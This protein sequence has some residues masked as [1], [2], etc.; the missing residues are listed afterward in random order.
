MNPREK[1]LLIVVISL[2]VLIGGWKGYG[3]YDEW[4]SDLDRQIERKEVIRDK[5]SM[6]RR[7]AEIGAATWRKIGKQT[8]SLEPTEGINIQRDE[9]YALAERVGLKNRSVSPPRPANWRKNGVRRLSCSLSA[10]G[11]V[12]QIVAFLYELETQP[13]LV[14][15]TS[16]TLEPSRKREE[17]GLMAL[18]LRL[19]TLVLPEN[20]RVADLET[21][22]LDPAK[23][24]PVQ[25]RLRLAS[26]AAYSAKIGDELFEAW[27]PPLPDA[28]ILQG[29][30]NNVKGLAREGVTLR[31]KAASGAKSYR[32]F[33]GQNVPS[34]RLAEVPTTT[35]K[36]PPEEMKGGVTYAWRIDS[37]NESG[38]TTGPVWK[39]T[40]E[41][42]IV[43]A[44]GDGQPPPPPPPPPKDGHLVIGRILSSPFGQ[45]IVLEDPRNKSAADQR[46]HV[47][48]QVFG[49]TLVFVD[50]KGA[51]TEDV[52]GGRWFHPIGE[53]LQSRIPLTETD[54]P[55][56]F[57]AIRKLVERMPGISQA[58][59]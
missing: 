15:C 55:E 51:V 6:A 17:K 34:K 36:V 7:R 9:L 20:K 22:E 56:V 58:P 47:G 37:V 30:P 25:D 39:F 23:R 27:K 43:D 11:R 46:K 5:A 48:E 42:D 28:V 14:R 3:W 45:Q 19:D 29:P 35:Y 24:K 50:L 1:K 31:W 26:S 41:G 59:E 10:A 52:Q 4:K 54:Q 53:P 12:N 16:L 18:R 33:L 57:H 40:T 21:A 13:Y 2:G 49:G 44:T 8:L 38:V 32:I